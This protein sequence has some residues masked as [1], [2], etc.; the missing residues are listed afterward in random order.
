MRKEI[1]ITKQLSLEL[2]NLR[3]IRY[4]LITLYKILYGMMDFRL[5]NM[6]V[7]ASDVSKCS[8]VGY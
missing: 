8:V 2:R 7:L 6:F 5:K 3:R 4:D 1:S